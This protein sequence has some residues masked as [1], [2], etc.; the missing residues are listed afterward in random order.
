MQ[1]ATAVSSPTAT[2]AA[3][4]ATRASSSSSGATVKFTASA[5]PIVPGSGIVGVS[6]VVYP[7]GAQT[8]QVTLGYWSIR[9]LAQSIRY[10]LAY[11][12]VPFADVRF[13]QG[14]APE[15]SRTAWTDLK[16]SLGIDF[17]NLPFYMEGQGQ[18]QLT[19]STTILRHLGRKHLL[20]G[21]S[22]VEQARCDLVLD[23]SYDFKSILVDTAYSRSRAEA[24]AHFAAKSIPHYF[25]QFETFRSK[26]S[27]LRWFAG[28][29]L[30]IADFFLFEMLAQASL[31]VPGC[32]EPYPLLRQF[33][34]DFESLPAI[35]LYRKS[36]AYI[37]RPCNNMAGFQ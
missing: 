8:P 18:L 1:K 34:T 16:D 21:A 17:P 9:G 3:T 4:M 6:T 29:N 12:G 31:M 19:Q 2:S 25:S 26:H 22:L 35:E 36:A 7:E 14:G 30:T 32:L 13:Q 5:D 28:E 20:Y 15:F 23:T 27:S 11:T 24:L 10:V 33:M 37:E